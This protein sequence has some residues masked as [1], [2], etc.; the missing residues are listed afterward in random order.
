LGYKFDGFK[1]K[2]KVENLNVE[3]VKTVHPDTIAAYRKLRKS[4]LLQLYSMQVYEINRNKCVPDSDYCMKCLVRKKE[5]EMVGWGGPV[6]CSL[7]RALL[8]VEF[9]FYK[10]SM[11]QEDMICSLCGG[12]IKKGQWHSSVIQFGYDPLKLCLRCL[13]PDEYG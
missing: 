13:M 7:V 2:P 12:E 6:G 10:M 1:E 5:D 8:A 4:S 9:G 3:W 11:A